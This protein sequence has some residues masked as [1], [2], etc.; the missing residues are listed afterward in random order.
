VIKEKS[1]QDEDEDSE[2]SKTETENQESDYDA[3]SQKSSLGKR[4]RST[5]TYDEDSEEYWNEVV[6]LARKTTKLNKR[7]R[8]CAE[9]LKKALSGSILRIEDGTPC[10]VKDEVTSYNSEKDE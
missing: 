1:S 4:S 8:K 10:Q 3:G 5:P 2:Q 9:K 7:L 6:M